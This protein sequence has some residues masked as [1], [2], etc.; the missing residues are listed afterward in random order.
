[1]DAKL[2]RSILSASNAF[3]VEG[4]L[5][6]LLEGR[7]AVVHVARDTFAASLV[8]VKSVSVAENLVVVTTSAEG[9]TTTF[10]E[11]DSVAAVA[12]REDTKAA[13]R[14]RPGFA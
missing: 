12:V 13:D 8:R 7:E 1:M 9:Q 3:R 10:L 14:K 5:Y 6:T 11:P 2:L 4:E